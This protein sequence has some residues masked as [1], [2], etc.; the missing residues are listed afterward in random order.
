M[1]EASSVEIMEA[2]KPS[3]PVIKPKTPKQSAKKS[4]TK[5]SAKKAVAEAPAKSPVKVT[6]HVHVPSSPRKLKSESP[7]KEEVKEKSVAIADEKPK[8]GKKST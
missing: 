3:S 1:I 5:K 8:T 7:S 2:E 4:T 6:E